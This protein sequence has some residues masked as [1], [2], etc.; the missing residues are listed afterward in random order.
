MAGLWVL[1]MIAV[2]VVFGAF[3]L[4]S[5]AGSGMPEPPLDGQAWP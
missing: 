5:I 3:S 1:V 2:A 4:R